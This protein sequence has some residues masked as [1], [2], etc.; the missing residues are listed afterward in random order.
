[1]PGRHVIAKN[2]LRPV[3]YDEEEGKGSDGY[4]GGI[5]RFSCGRGAERCH[6]TELSRSHPT[7]A[8]NETRRAVYVCFGDL[9]QQVTD[10]LPL[11]GKVVEES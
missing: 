10:P 8:E 11:P 1:V 6:K 2:I 5:S 9:S 3:Q 7:D 4:D